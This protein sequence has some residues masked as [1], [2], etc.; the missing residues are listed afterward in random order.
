[1]PFITKLIRTISLN[2][3]M[4]WTLSSVLAIL[5]LTIYENRTRILATFTAPEISNIVGLVFT[6]GPDTQLRIKEI[7][8]AEPS[9][10]GIMISSADLR[11]NE[12]R[13]LSF[14]ASDVA[15]RRANETSM[16]VS[17]GRIPLFTNMDV[18]NAAIIQLI[19]GHFACVPTTT[20]LLGQ[21]YP[22]IT[23]SN[24]AACRAS[25]PSYYGYFSGYV[26]FFL[27]E[28]PSNA[29]EAQVKLIIEKLAND[30]Y[31]RDVLTTLR[32]E[33]NNSSTSG[34]G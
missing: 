21:L 28:M 24:K 18:S 16:R 19:N 33:K 15:L 13:I 29:K 3:V 32:P 20:T 25:I 23:A 30:I 8:D 12:S 26:T 27:S 9:I 5:F 34:H 6:V 7:V 14:Y 22:E 31:F 2:R 11:L 4:I 1:M 10:T 17:S